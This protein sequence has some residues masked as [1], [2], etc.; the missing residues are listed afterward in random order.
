MVTTKLDLLDKQQEIRTILNT[1]PTNPGSKFS[2]LS[3]L[4]RRYI[5]DV[6]REIFPDARE[7]LK[8]ETDDAIKEHGLADN[9]IKKLQND[10]YDEGSFSE[11]FHCVLHSMARDTRI[12]SKLQGTT[13]AAGFR[14]STSI[15]SVCAPPS[16]DLGEDDGREEDA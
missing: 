13:K 12:H 7:T 9:L 4:F 14:G 1:Y 16:L 6:E 15:T 8:T 11:V 2:E 10:P 5:N 3:R